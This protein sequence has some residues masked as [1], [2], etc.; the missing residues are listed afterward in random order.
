MIYNRAIKDVDLRPMVCWV[1]GF[2]PH[3]D[4]D[5][6]LL[7]VLCVA[8]DRSLLL[9]YR[10][11]VGILQNEMSWGLNVKTGNEEALAYYGLRRL[12]IELYDLS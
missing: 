10:S 7:R 5:L 9:A 8:N 1:C 3:W 4:L 6:C 11:S 2:E 12:S